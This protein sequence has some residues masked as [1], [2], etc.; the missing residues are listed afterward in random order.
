[1][2][3]EF[4]DKLSLYGREHTC[5]VM[6]GLVSMYQRFHNAWKLKS[7][8][9]TVFSFC[10]LYGTRRHVETCR[11][12]LK[13]LESLSLRVLSLL[14]GMSFQHGGVCR[15]GLAALCAHK[16]ARL[17]IHIVSTCVFNITFF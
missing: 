11:F 5:E 7:S 9:C 16:C 15:F 4:L 8:A 1:M 10:V 14:L 6:E 12:V 17:L 3:K 2:M 13:E